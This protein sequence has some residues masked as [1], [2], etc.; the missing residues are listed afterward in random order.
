[1]AKT[2]QFA[3]APDEVGRDFAVWRKTRQGRAPIPEELWAR[4]AKLAVRQGVFKTSHA[5]RL[6]HSDLKRRVEALTVDGASKS[7]ATFVELFSPSSTHVHIADCVMEAESAAGA[8]LRI[9][10]KNVAPPALTAIIRDFVR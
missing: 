6:N 3:E 8:R 4:A 2:Q 10:I 9:A 7:S 1:M 5:L